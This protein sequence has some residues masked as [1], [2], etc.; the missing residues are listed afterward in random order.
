M[1]WTGPT[2]ALA[3]G[4]VWFALGS[5]A[6]AQTLEQAMTAAYV[7]NPTLN[8][9][10]A[11]VRATDENVPRALSGYRPTVTGAAS[12]AKTALTTVTNPQ[13]IGPIFIPSTQSNKTLDQSTLQLTIN[14]N[15]YNGFRTAN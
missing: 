11:A 8:A 13:T 3:A 6:A 7:N 4:V 2:P 15:L 10:R 5:G 12:A 1:T 9:Q 14:Q